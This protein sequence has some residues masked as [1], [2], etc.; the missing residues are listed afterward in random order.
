MKTNYV[1]IDYE[2]VQVKSLALLTGEQFRVRVFLGPNNTKLPI[3]LVLAMQELGDRAEYIILETPGANALDFHI[4]YYLGVLATADPMG[5]FHIISKDTGFD[6]LIKHL[7]AKKVLSTRSVLI[8]EMPCFAAAETNGYSSNG[9]VIEIKQKSVPARASVDDLIKVAIDDL[10]K[11]KASKPRTPKTLLNT[12]HAK[13]GKGV[14]VTDI[15]AVFVG[16]VTRGYVKVNGA[17]VTYA[18][19]VV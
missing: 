12:I 10:I 17:K 1:L 19:P 9:G 6:P 4:A 3:E 7:K 11:R 13:C 8:E 5:F 16:L 15:E 14:S 18:L 2:N